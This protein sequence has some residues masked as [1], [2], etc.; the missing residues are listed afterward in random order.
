MSIQ[1]ENGTDGCLCLQ[2]KHVF[3]S[4]N[5]P[6]KGLPLQVVPMVMH[7]IAVQ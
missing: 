1:I 2:G 6:F 7:I 3:L 5:D 4:K